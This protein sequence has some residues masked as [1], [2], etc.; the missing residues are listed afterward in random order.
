[1]AP[2]DPTEWTP[3]PHMPLPDGFEPTMQAAP[4]RPLKPCPFDRGMDLQ[5]WRTPRFPGFPGPNPGSASNPSRDFFEFFAYSV[6][7]NSCAA[8]GPWEKSMAGAERAW[9]GL[10][11]TTRFVEPQP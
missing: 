1:M 6:H 5:M 11:G 2:T 3:V 4:S 8:D 7:C 10:P 9:N